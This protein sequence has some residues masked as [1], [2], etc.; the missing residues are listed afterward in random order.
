MS[1]NENNNN[2]K[3]LDKQKIIDEINNYPDTIL[4][5]A[6]DSIVRKPTDF[7]GLNTN[8]DRECHYW[9]DCP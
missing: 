2:N 7:P 5:D 3:E 4:A 9:M 1:D 8:D 6:A